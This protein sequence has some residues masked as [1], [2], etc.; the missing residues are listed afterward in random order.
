MNRYNIFTLRTHSGAAALAA[1]AMMAITFELS[2]SLP[3]RMAVGHAATRAS[4]MTTAG[5]APIT[6][7]NIV[8]ERIEVVAVRS[9]TVATMDSNRDNDQCLRARC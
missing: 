3:A 8:P 1:I 5:V 9:S 6:E 4:A 7:V 2:V